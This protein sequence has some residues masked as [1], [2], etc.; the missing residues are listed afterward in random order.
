LTPSQIQRFH[1]ATLELLATVGVK[2]LHPE[3]VELLAAAGCSVTDENRVRIAAR[4]VERCLRSAPREIVLYDRL[5]REAMRLTGRRSHFGLGTDLIHTHD[6]D[7][8]E[9]RPTR[10]DDVERAAT[11]ADALP[12]IDFVASYG[13]PHDSP[14]NLMYIDSY[15]RQVEHTVKPIFFTAAGGADLAVIHA[16]AAEVAGGDPA[17][18]T[19]PTLIHYAE[20]LTPLTHTASG[21]EKLLYCAA[22]DIPV[23]YASGMM[24]G[25]TAPVTLAAAVTLGN[26]EALSGLVIH[27]LKSPGAPIVSGF[28]M[29]TLDMRHATCSYGCPEYRLA[30]SAC[31]DLYHHYGIPMWGTAGASDSHLPDQQAAMEWAISLTTACLDGAN[32]IHD[33]GYLGQGLV[34]HPAAIVMCAEIISYVKRLRRGFSMDAEH[35]DLELIGR[36]GPMGNYLATRHTLTHY[37][38]EHWQPQLTSRQPLDVWRQAADPSWTERAVASARALLAS[39]HPEPLAPEPLRRLAALRSEAHARIGAIAFET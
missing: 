23:T 16:M 6:L 3:A 25:G 8:G 13:L 33:V 5:G 30:I 34:G 14:T 22:H 9:L 7:S 20:P 37:R 29:A 39:H 28:G 36:V 21:L 12:D 2:V 18:R 19:K 17:L 31:A 26:A 4:L 1:H 10:L 27:Q 11:L 15:L 32:L 24:S 35:L 38:R